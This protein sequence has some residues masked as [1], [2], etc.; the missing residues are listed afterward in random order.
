[1]TDKL[2]TWKRFAG[3]GCLVAGTIAHG[4]PALAEET[5][6]D[7]LE[8]FNRGMFAVNEGLDT[9]LIKP[10]A[11]AYDFV[12]PLPAKAGDTVTKTQSAVVLE[13][14]ISQFLFNK[15]AEGQETK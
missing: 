10:V 6:H 8:G 15:A 3:I 12:V 13:K 4:G 9:V 2:M 1:M 5:V 14:L 11:Q 7:P